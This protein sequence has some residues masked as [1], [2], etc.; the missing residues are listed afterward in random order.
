M[1]SK[2]YEAAKEFVETFKIS[3]EEKEEDAKVLQLQ[4]SEQEADQEKKELIGDMGANKGAEEKKKKKKKKKK[5]KKK[6][7]GP[8]VDQSAEST[9]EKAGT[10]FMSS[11]FMFDP[12]VLYENSMKE[13]RKQELWSNVKRAQRTGVYGPSYVDDMMEVMATGKVWGNM[14]MADFMRAESSKS[15]A[16]QKSADEEYKK[17]MESQ[18]EELTDFVKFMNSV[19]SGDY[20]YDSDS[21]SD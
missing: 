1:D 9:G 16:G 13:A 2:F 11:N 7:K 15:K 19:N 20:A 18:R 4:T 10:S 5:N 6:K 8:N 12:K 17:M 21:D 14:T 3:F